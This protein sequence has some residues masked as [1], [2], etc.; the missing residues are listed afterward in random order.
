M[1]PVRHHYHAH[2]CCLWPCCCTRH[3]PTAIWPLMVWPRQQWHFFLFFLS[4]VLA[5]LPAS[6]W[7]HCLRQAV[8]VA[9][10]AP[11][12]LPSWPSKVRPMQRWHLPVLRWRFARIPL[13]SLPA[14]CYC[15]CCWCCAGIITLGARAS[16]SSLRAPCGEFRPAAVLAIRDVLAV[17]SVIEARP[18]FSVA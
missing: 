11:A 13:V 1:L 18:P 4:V 15:C 17:S 10:I 12:L 16:F 14:S 9:G 7:H 5:F 6:H 8:L 3:R 2:H